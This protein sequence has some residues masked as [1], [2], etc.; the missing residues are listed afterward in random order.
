MAAFLDGTLPHAVRARVTNHIA[1]CS[2]CGELTIRA[3]AD[4]ASNSRPPGS[5]GRPFVGQLTPGSRVDR[6]QVLGAIGRGG[7]SEVYAAYHPDLDR[8]IALKVVNESGADAPEQRARLLREARAIAR[9]SHPNVV[10]VYDAG[11]VGDR[12][13]IAMEFVAGETVDAWLK[14]E[15]RGWREIL[16]VFLAAGCGLA[17]AHAAGVVHRDFK[18]QNVMIGRDGSVR[19]MDFGLARLAEEPLDAASAIGSDDARRARPA[20]VTKTGAVVGTLA[21]M[22]PEQFARGPVDARADSSASALRCT[23]R[24]TELGPPSLIFRPNTQSRATTSRSHRVH[25][26]SLGGSGAP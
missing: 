4:V 23:R 13:Y 24:C 7:M 6:Y 5:E 20:T 15:T 8:R 19:V 12:V 17:A 9:L 21:Y 14:S 16:G 11:T 18:P 26:A 2:A 25:P 22:A 10:A 3:A 1:S